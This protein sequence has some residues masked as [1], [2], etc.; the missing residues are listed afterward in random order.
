MRTNT[1]NNKSAQKM[2]KNVGIITIQN[3]MNYGACLQS[4]ALWYR[5]KSLGYNCEIINLL[6]PSHK[7]FKRAKNSVHM[8]EKLAS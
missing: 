4:F 3:I 6:T 5:I 8:K 1:F 7:G 2:Q